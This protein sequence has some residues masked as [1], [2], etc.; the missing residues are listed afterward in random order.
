M[1]NLLIAV[2]ERITNLS[3]HDKQTR[4][5]QYVI[6]QIVGDYIMEWSNTILSWQN[7]RSRQHHYNNVKGTKAFHKTQ[8]Q[9]FDYAIESIVRVFMQPAGAILLKI[10][11]SREGTVLKSLAIFYYYICIN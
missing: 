7:K 8:L 5:R 3:K 4:N 9:Y 2:R 10:M 6:N 11:I 1:R